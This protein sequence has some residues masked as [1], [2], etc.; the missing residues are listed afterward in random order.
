[1]I[2]ELKELERKTYL[3]P[4][5]KILLTT[6]GSITRILET[7]SG[8]KIEVETQ[9]QR[10]IEASSEIAELLNI[11]KNDEVNYRVVNLRTSKRIL[12]HAFS[13][14]PLKRIKKEFREDIMKRD[15]PI[16]KI[17]TKLKIE[18]RREI[19]YFDII[20]AN[21]KFARIFKIPLISPLLK[22][23]YNIINQGKVMI[24]ITEIFPYEEF[25]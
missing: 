1:M 12:V 11:S 8:E 17:M 15:L 21:E 5:H 22:R 20:M 4:V 6:D 25:K 14:T 19:N 10:V 2:E 16:G 23:N 13:Y 18:S 7:L 3:S 9:V 24:N